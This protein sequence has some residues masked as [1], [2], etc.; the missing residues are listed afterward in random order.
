MGLLD[1]FANAPA[2]SGFNDALLAA[3]QALLTPRA[4]GGGMGAAFGAFPDAMNRAQQR[5]MQNRLFGLKEQQLGMEAEKAAREQAAAE[6]Q[7]AQFAQ[8]IKSLP[9]DQQ[10]VA[11]MV[12]PK[13]FEGMAPKLETVY[14]PDGQEQKAYLFGPG[15]SP[16]F[17]GGPKKAQMPWEYELGPDGR[18]RMR[19]EVFDA[20]RQVASAGAARID[21]RTEVKMG[22]SVGAQIGPILKTERERTEGSLNLGRSG[23]D[24]IAAIESGKVI[25]GPGASLRLFGAQVADL[26]GIGGKDNAEKL[27]NTRRVI[28][29]LADAAVE[30][31]K[32]LAGQGQVT[33][34][35]ARAVE[36]ASSGN[37]DDLTADEIR[38]IAGLNVKAAK[39]TARGYQQQLDAMPESMRSARPFYQIPGLDEWTRPD[40]RV[41]VNGS[42]PPQRKRFNPQTGQLE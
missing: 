3:A 24:I 35:E 38:L 28:R 31:R 34:N 16:E 36:K 20:K 27:Q 11:M 37:I 14:T 30:A 12:G 1:N 6:R 10:R 5:Q 21:N 40:V 39:L 15:S 8:A 41:E 22:E 7:Q 42:T 32:R 9:P 2:E 23:Q 18:P 13:Y 25:A 33:E 29:G 17:V 4:R 19:P 26:L